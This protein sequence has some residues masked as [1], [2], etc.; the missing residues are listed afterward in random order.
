MNNNNDLDL[1][2]N[3]LENIIEEIEEDYHGNYYNSPLLQLINTLWNKKIQDLDELFDIEQVKIDDDLSELELYGRTTSEVRENYDTYMERV[4]HMKSLLQLI[5]DNKI[6]PL[7]KFIENLKRYVSDKKELLEEFEK[8]LYKVKVGT[9]EGLTRD[10]I[11]NE[12]IEVDEDN[13]VKNVLEQ[14]YDEMEKLFPKGVQGGK[15]RSSKKYRKNK[16]KKNKTKKRK[17]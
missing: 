11:D 15:H 6:V 9:L 16:N 4:T 7:E 5:N 14:P 3:N 1:I 10:V 17:G 12:N 8:Q 13:V 2:F